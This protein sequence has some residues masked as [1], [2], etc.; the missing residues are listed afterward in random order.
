MF[1]GTI[2]IVSLVQDRMGDTPPKRRDFW[3][4]A[5]LL[6]KLASGVILLWFTVVVKEGSEEI[7]TAMRRGELVQRLIGDLTA[8]PDARVRQDLAIIALDGSIGAEDSEMVASIVEKLFELRPTTTAEQLTN[9][10]A[11]AVL[12]KRSPQRAS[13]IRKRVLDAL[14]DSS[15]RQSAVSSPTLPPPDTAPGAAPP[16]VPDVPA[17]AKAAAAV[18]SNLLY[19]QFQGQITRELINELRRVHQEE[20]LAAPAAERV[21]GDY[22]STVRY[23]HDDDR[24]KAEAVAERSKR[25]FQEKNCPL[26]VGVEPVTS[27]RSKV[28]AGQ[29]EL[30]I[31][32]SCR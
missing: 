26:S 31:N 29:L 9:D 8:S 32:H 12:S 22:K 24:T 28:P 3:D 19:I 13:A 14:S 6:F 21:A 4:Y 11:F 30:W 20:G 5:D 16:V 25:F 7:A 1:G 15:V 27:S 10:T 17:E 23:F 18:F 2:S